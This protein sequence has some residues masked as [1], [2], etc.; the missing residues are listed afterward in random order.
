MSMN[1]C[2]RPTTRNGVV[3]ATNSSRATPLGLLE[4]VRRGGNHGLRMLG[5][6]AGGD[7]VE[8][9]PHAGALAP[10]QA[11]ESAGVEVGGFVAKEGF[12]APLDVGRGPGTEAVAFGNDPVV[13]EGVQHVAFGSDA[14][15]DSDTRA[16][17]RIGAGAIDMQAIRLGAIRGR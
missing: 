5:T 3:V 16:S 13:A 1:H 17:G 9:A 2:E 10:H 4:E 7:P 14:R 11:K 6:A 12:H 8:E 15:F